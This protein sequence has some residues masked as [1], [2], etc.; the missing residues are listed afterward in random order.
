MPQGWYIFRWP[1]GTLSDGRGQNIEKA[2]N[3]GDDHIAR[4]LVGLSPAEG[5]LRCDACGGIHED[6][7]AAWKTHGGPGVL[8]VIEEIVEART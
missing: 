8:L 5:G 4:A 7:D 6:E 2:L 3:I 1:T